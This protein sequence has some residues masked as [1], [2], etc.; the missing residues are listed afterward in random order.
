[1]NMDLELLRIEIATRLEAVAPMFTSEMR[2]TFVARHPGNPECIVIVTDDN[3]DEM[4]RDV[5]A[6]GEKT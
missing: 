5:K 3:L 1:M 2:L 4:L 6:Q